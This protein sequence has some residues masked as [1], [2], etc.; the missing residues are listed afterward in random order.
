[1]ANR[2]TPALAFILGF[3]FF[4]GLPWALTSLAL[5]Q[6]LTDSH[7]ALGMIG[8]T[9]NIGLAYTLKFLFA[10]IIDRTL[11]TSLGRRRGWLIVTQIAMCAGAVMLGFAH[12]GIPA[13]AI[14]AFIAF[15]SACQDIAID[16]WRIESYPRDTQGKALAAYVWG[17]RGAAL[18]AGSGA[19]ALSA[20]AN[21]HIALL[22]I[23]ALLACAPVLSWFAPEPQLLHQPPPGLAA[24]AAPVR[25]MLIRPGIVPLLSFVVLFKLGEALA[26]PM[27][28]PFYHAMGFTRVQV[29]GVL[30][31]PLLAAVMLGSAAGG[32][33]VSRFGAQRALFTT[34]FMQ[35]A[36]M[37]AYFLLALYPGQV[38]ILYL[39]VIVENFAEAMADASFL[40]FLSAQC[41]REF[42]ATQYALLS[43]LAA[44]PLR[45]VGGFS[46]VLAAHL[47]WVWF[48][49]ISIFTALPAM[50]VMRRYLWSGRDNTEA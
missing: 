46:G 29:A 27:A 20:A 30:S 6:W 25:D 19:I 35:M 2:P 24:Y 1:M 22:V 21:W 43:S 5:R 49:G 4:S 34:G 33:L 36:A 42:T 8:I 45:T 12:P 26:T 31:F 17:F 28:Q 47:G 10:P 16:A 48:Y 3:G 37:S 7:A 41:R 15:A 50:L 39:K 32:L 9:A 11:L 13:L 18:V 40:A 23:A 14:S 44:V 38:P